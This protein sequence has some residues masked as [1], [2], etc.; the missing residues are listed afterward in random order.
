VLR[1]VT[2]DEADRWRR[3]C[4]TDLRQG[5]QKHNQ[6]P[7]YHPA[8]STTQREWWIKIGERVKIM[9]V[10]CRGNCAGLTSTNKMELDAPA[11]TRQAAV[12][13]WQDASAGMVDGRTLLEDT[14]W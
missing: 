11:K 3:G 14:G 7:W 12:C 5:L 1:G 10:K 9:A 13:P 4:R 6:S 2:G 8:L